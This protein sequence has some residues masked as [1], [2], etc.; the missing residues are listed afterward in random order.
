MSD[1]FHGA[2]GFYY[3][4]GYRQVPE[5]GS[6]VPEF[7]KERVDKNI[8]Y[9]SEF[10]VPSTSPDAEYEFYV[11]AGN[12]KGLSEVPLKYVKG[13]AG[14]KSKSVCSIAFIVRGGLGIR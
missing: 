3:I 5:S 6:N 8:T 14:A 7:T 11:H 12:E 9:A 13:K 2:P 10:L 4:V 1:V